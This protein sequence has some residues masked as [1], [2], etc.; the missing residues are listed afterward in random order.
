MFESQIHS[1]RSLRVV[2]LAVAAMVALAGLMFVPLAEAQDGAEETVTSA[3]V[4]DA[5]VEQFARSLEEV[6]VIQQRLKEQLASVQD[7]EEAQRLQQQANTEMLQAV[8]ANGLQPPRYNVIARSISADAEL[9]QRIQEKRQ[10]L[11][12]GD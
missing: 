12:E 4:P 7:K 11:Q 1:R 3:D 2:L 6:L 9:N 10:E 5:E 8:E